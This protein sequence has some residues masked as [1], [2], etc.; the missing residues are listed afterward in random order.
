MKL[1]EIT[2]DSRAHALKDTIRYSEDNVRSVTLKDSMDLLIK[3]RSLT[4]NGPMYRTIVLQGE[5]YKKS[6]DLRQIQF[7]IQKYMRKV[8]REHYQAWSYSLKG[9]QQAVKTNAESEV[10]G[11]GEGWSICPVIRQHGEGI[12]VEA[13]FTAAGEDYWLRGEDEVFAKWSNDIEIYGFL[14]G[15]RT[16]RFYPVSQ[17]DEMLTYARKQMEKSETFYTP[18]HKR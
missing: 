7:Q 4:Y 9:M 13:V 10:Y 14:W 18:P 16:Q 11:E 3:D 15:L 17:T 2:D 1:F 6:F 8:K 5:P 12:D